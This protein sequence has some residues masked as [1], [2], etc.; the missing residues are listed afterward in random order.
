M[1]QPLVQACSSNCVCKVKA[2]TCL[3]CGSLPS[4]GCSPVQTVWDAYDECRSYAESCGG[5]LQPVS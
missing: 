1:E 5:A 2:R 3:A 4:L